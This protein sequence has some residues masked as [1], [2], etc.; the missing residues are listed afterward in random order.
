MFEFYQRHKA[1]FWVAGT[2]AAAVGLFFIIWATAGTS[3]PFIAAAGAKI[4]LNLGFLSTWSVPA[5]SAA[6]AAIVS[7]AG[8][9]AA[10]ITSITLGLANKARSFFKCCFC[11][12]KNK[13][14]TPDDDPTLATS[15][16]ANMVAAGMTPGK[17]DGEPREKAT[18]SPTPDTQG[19]ANDEEVAKRTYDVASAVQ[20]VEEERSGVRSKII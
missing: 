17:K 2:A 16:H 1:A 12:P 8:F 14:D 4:G 10:V 20:P 13:E 3:L 5:A 18:A 19:A 15:S 11:Q 9:T 7:G 6:A